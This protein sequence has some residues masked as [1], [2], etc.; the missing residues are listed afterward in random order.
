[1]VLSFFEYFEGELER[2]GFF[3]PAGKRPVVQRNLRNI[4]HRMGMTEQDVR[5]LRGA[6]VRLVE[7]PRAA[8]KTRRRIRPPKK[9]PD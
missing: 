6:L 3:R 2:N 7:G 8:P 1:M 5:S 4:F 9:L